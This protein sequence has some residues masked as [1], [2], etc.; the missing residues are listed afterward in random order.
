M[1]LDDNVWTAGDMDVASKEDFYKAALEH[2]KAAAKLTR[3]RGTFGLIYGTVALVMGAAFAAGG[4]VLY[5]KTPTLPPPQYI[6][7]DVAAGV[8]LPAVSAKDA[9]KLF[10][11]AV[12]EAAIR[13]FITACHSYLPE[14][15]RKIDWHRCMIMAT[16]DEQK[17]L[18]ADMGPNGSRYPVAMFGANGWAMPTDFPLGAFQPLGTVGTGA[19]TVYRYEVRYA[20][21]EVIGGKETT[22]HYTAQL[23]FSFYPDAK[24]DPNDRQL[25]R[26]G[27]Q[28]SAFSTT[29]D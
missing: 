2:R 19:D 8:V 4:A 20:R 29:R 11:E 25:N 28:A 3:S 26:S 22:P 24:M 18:A 16:P 15:W 9:P 14:T 5:S 12:R 1:P 10:P 21:T 17:R 23:A 7:V 6:P 27:M 13:E